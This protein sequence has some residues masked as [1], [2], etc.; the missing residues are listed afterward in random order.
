MNLPYLL[1]SSLAPVQEEIM[2]NLD[3]AEVA[4]LSAVSHNIRAS[5]KCRLNSTVHNIN[6]QLAK[7]FKD[8][9]A[10][11]QIQARERALITGDFARAFFS[12]TTAS[13]NK[14]LI[15]VGG[16]KNL[17]IFKSY[18][19]SDGWTPTEILNTYDRDAARQYSYCDAVYSKGNAEQNKLWIYL[20]FH[21]GPCFATEIYPGYE[22]RDCNKCDNYHAPIRHVIGQDFT[23]GLNFISSERAYCL[24]PRLTILENRSYVIQDD[25]DQCFRQESIEAGIA[26]WKAAGVQNVIANPL[27]GPEIGTAEAIFKPIR[28]VGDKRTW[29]VDLDAT[30]IDCVNSSD[31]LNLESTTFKLHREW[32]WYNDGSYYTPVMAERFKQSIFKDTHIVFYS[33]GFDD[34]APGTKSNEAYARKVVELEEKYTKITQEQIR[35]LP[36][37]Y[38][39]NIYI[40]FKGQ[41]HAWGI[42]WRY[43][44][45]ESMLA[46]PADFKNH[47]RIHH[48]GGWSYIDNEQ[49]LALPTEWKERLFIDDLDDWVY[50]DDEQLLAVS[51]ESKECM[52]LDARSWRYMD[53]EQ[54]Q[55]VPAE[56]KKE[57]YTMPLDEW[58]FVNDEQLLALPAG[59]EL[60]I[61]S[62]DLENLESWK[63]YDDELRK[64]LNRLFEEFEHQQ[65]LEDEDSESTALD[66]PE[67]ADEQ[68]DLAEQW[69]SVCN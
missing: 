14:L 55:A 13:V 23:A 46:L 62:S 42:C 20:K 12:G 40:T 66:S 52:H 6:L 61:R 63:Y 15:F 5:I 69:N 28:R 22:P 26:E 27:Y 17:P 53:D 19:E 8:P 10:F 3:A 47:L 31:L 30:G 44:N 39:K 18:L 57:L 60:N 21:H 67:D 2:N 38:K 29:I 32:Y 36:A 48:S 56:L 41:C 68:L 45:D 33:P 7:F 50:I 16:A 35:A 34:N 51:A 11:R 58:R 54:L 43:D 25:V 49:L 65:D 59:F 64:D 37:E 4:T 24:Y 1:S 9:T